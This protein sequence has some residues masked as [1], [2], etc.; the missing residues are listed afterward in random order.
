MRRR[1]HVVGSNP[2]DVFND[3][4][5]LREAQGGSRRMKSKETFARF[6]HDRALAL[7]GKIHSAAWVVLIELDR[8]LL[9]NRGQNPI[10]LTSRNLKAAGLSSR[11][12][13]R[14][15]R[16]LENAGVIR[17]HNR[18]RGRCPLV[19]HLWYPIQT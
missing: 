10:P 6:P 17:I 19:A 16:E 18:G 15:L 4:S 11:S 14:A 2:A 8:V 9:K 1:F 13:G 3:L 5:A 12:K 7:Y